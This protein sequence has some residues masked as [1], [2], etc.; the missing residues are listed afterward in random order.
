MAAGVAESAVR[1]REVGLWGVA[2]ST[3]ANVDEADLA[4]L[5]KQEEVRDV[6]P[7]VRIIG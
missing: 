6:S 1:D 5:L 4:A 3:E 7:Y 2:V